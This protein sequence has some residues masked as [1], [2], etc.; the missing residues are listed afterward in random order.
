[1]EDGKKTKEQ[2]I[3][4]L[5]N[6]RKQ[7]S[8]LKKLITAFNRMKEEQEASLNELESIFENVREGIVLIDLKGKVLKVNKRIIEVSGFSENEVVGRRFALLRMFPLKYR[9]QMYTKFTKELAGVETPPLEVE[10]YNKAGEKVDVEIHGSIINIKGKGKVVVAILRVITERR[11]LENELRKSEEKYR[12]IAESTRDLIAITT[13]S[14][15]PTYTYISPSHKIV[16]GYESKDLI[17][18]SAFKFIHPNDKKELFPLLKKYIE[19]KS[20]RILNGSEV[21]ITETLEFRA[22]D[23]S[24]NWHFLESTA[25]KIGKHIL[26]ISRDVTER[27][28]AEREKQ[29]L[30]EKLVLSEKMEAIGR[31]AGGVAHDLNNI[32]NAMVGYPDL[33]LT[34]LPETSPLRDTIL[35]IKQSGV[36][37]A[38]LVEDLLTL[39]RRGVRIT[40]VLNLNDIITD[41]LKSP[42][43]KKLE[44]VYP[45]VKIIT[46]LDNDL[47]NIEGSPVH[48]SKTI[49]NLVAN[50]SEAIPLRGLINISTT[51]RYVEEPVKVFKSSVKKGKYVVLRVSDNGTG[52]APKY[53]DRIFEP[54]FTKKVM[55]KS[56]TGLGMSVVWWTINDHKGYIN[57]KSKVRQGTAF[58]LYFP[59]TTKEVSIKK[60]SLI[61]DREK[62]KGKGEKILVV[63]DEKDQGELLSM[64]L[65]KLGYTVDTVMSGEKAIEYTRSSPVD[66]LVLDMI[67]DPGL[68]GL[69]TYREIIKQC[70]G[71]KAIIMS[72]FTETERVKEALKLGA[73]GFVRKPY[74]LN[75]MGTAVRNELDKSKQDKE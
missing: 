28:Q 64:L 58:E 33:L 12:L 63:D 48:L 14:R 70:P 1:M 31:V 71:T 7:V 22:R 47:L 3:D 26:F 74:T 65:T 8:E 2:L 66:L 35:S 20:K 53:L 72:G 32:L 42:E 67:M 11:K 52:I 16:L 59:A 45:N 29:E 69:D 36:K 44:A 25:N 62:I 75:A 73:G 56:G 34:N 37:A 60:T 15:R 61:V 40:E 17:G 46:D 10:G 43:C 49:M 38:R 13:F 18:Q 54:F 19:A 39:T 55:G 21:E 5:T 24:G 6:L 9:I 23:K 51:N 50:A 57:V 68:D 27:K 4:E 30:V 41:Y